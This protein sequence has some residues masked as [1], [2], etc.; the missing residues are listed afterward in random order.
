VYTKFYTLTN[1]QRIILY[2]R[3]HTHTHRDYINAAANQRPPVTHFSVFF[4]VFFFTLFTGG[5]K[6]PGGVNISI[7]EV[8]DLG[9]GCW[10]LVFEGGTESEWERGNG[11]ESHF[12][13]RA[14][15]DGELQGV[16]HV[17]DV[18]PL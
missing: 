9:V 8:E 4:R 3:A 17:R 12:F 13:A 14:L 6:V 10:G 11:R 18:T 16:T 2:A 15:L 7:V 5:N 1:T